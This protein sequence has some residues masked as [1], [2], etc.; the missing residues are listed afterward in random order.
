MFEPALFS[1]NGALC[2]AA[3]GFAAAVKRGR[4]EALVLAGLLLAN[5]IFCNLAYTPYAPKLGLAAIGI[6]A[7]S[8]ELWMLADTLLAASC[9]LVAFKRWW[10][11]ALWAAGAVQILIHL[12][13][14][15]ELFSPD[16]Y[17]DLL[18]AVLLAQLAVF[19][20]IGGPGVVDLLHSTLAHFRSRRRTVAASRYSSPE[21]PVP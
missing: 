11:W 6:K 3:I 13:Y 2:V 14:S 12:L 19:F 20:M 4:T 10:G 21:E 15:F 5:F 18:Q 16:A 7:T 17:S 9:V 1:F 8:K